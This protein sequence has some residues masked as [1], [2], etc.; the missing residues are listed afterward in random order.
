[1]SKLLVIGAGGVSSVCV[2]KMAMN[3]QIFPDIHLA[4]RTIAKCDA[5]AASVKSRTGITV[6]TYEIDAEEVPAM[7]KLIQTIGATHVINLAL[8]YQDLPIMDAC[9]EAGA[10]YLDTANYEPKD[11]AKFEYKWQWAYQDR[12]KQAGLMALLGSGFD[13]GVTSVFTMWL[14]KHKLKTIRT[15]DILD[16]NGGDHGQ[17]FATNFNPEINIR[18]VTAPARHW[19]NGAWVETPAMQVSTPFD[20][21]EVGTRQAYLMYHEEL[22]SLSK[23]NPE[24]ERA[25]F[26]M[27]F[28]DEYIKHLT[29]LQNVGMT[30]IEPIMYQGKE[31]IPLQFLA[32]VL[33]K[34]ETLG[35]TTKGNTNIGCIA[36]GEALDGSGEKTFYINNICSHEAAYEETGNQAV[37]YTTGVPAMIG[38]AMMVSG[39]W[40]GEGV[41]N[42]EE[43]D[44]DPF[45]EM[46]NQ[47][48]LP[49]QVKELDGPV[50][51]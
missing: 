14:K 20:F 34:P 1:M 2:H 35:E 17:A 38:S 47:H 4:S 11:E 40:S 27:T 45:M 8:P 29:V 24:I 21:D 6:P 44:P 18:E 43:M 15:L 30:G 31:I 41:F 39:T 7:V 33:P 12:F 5:I 46:L 28:G 51:F 37:S 10:H 9:L 42:M 23:F 19:E 13:P 16:C 49:W 25:R 3:A 50:S 26:W 22:E 32:A 36:T 48:G